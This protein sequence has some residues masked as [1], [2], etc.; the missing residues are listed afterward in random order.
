MEPQPHGRTSIRSPPR[1]TRFHDSLPHTSEEW[2]HRRSQSPAPRGNNAAR[3]NSTTFA[4]SPDPIADYCFWASSPSYQPACKHEDPMWLE[5]SYN[6]ALTAGDQ[7]YYLHEAGEGP[8]SPTYVPVS[9]LWA[10]HK[11][12]PTLGQPRKRSFLGRGSN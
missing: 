7:Y 4:V 3:N 10:G 2:E 11:Q 5:C 1:M 8:H 12:A 6:L 9:S